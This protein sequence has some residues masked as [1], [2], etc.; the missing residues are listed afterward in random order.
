MKF[1]LSMIFLCIGNPE[2][3]ETI[4]GRVYSYDNIFKL[5]IIKT[6]RNAGTAEETFADSVMI[7]ARNIKNL[8]II[9]QA[10]KS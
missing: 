9:E 5:V 8:E 4:V 1:N 10:P 6:V 2:P 7:N 3:P